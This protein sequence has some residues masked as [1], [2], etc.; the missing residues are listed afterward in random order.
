MIGEDVEASDDV[1]AGT[2]TGSN[3]L[4]CLVE[5]ASGQQEVEQSCTFS[6]VAVNIATGALIVTYPMVCLCRMTTVQVTLSLMSLKT[7]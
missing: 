4:L 2:T 1:T 3:Y 6:L 7:M 5:R